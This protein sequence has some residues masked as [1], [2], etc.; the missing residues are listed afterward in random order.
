MICIKTQGNA[1]Y[2][3][4]ILRNLLAGFTIAPRC[5]LNQYTVF[6]TEIDRQSVKLEFTGI[7]NG[8]IVLL[9]FQFAADAPINIQCARRLDIG[10]GANGKHG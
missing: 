5:R 2:G 10:F 4:D 1:V 7:F 6:V 9:E 8:R 3:A